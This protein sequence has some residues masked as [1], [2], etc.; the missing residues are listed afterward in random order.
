[1]RKN[2]RTNQVL[3]PGSPFDVHIRNMRLICRDFPWPI[4]IEDNT[5][6]PITWHNIRQAI[7]EAL[8]VEMT[9]AEWELAP[10]EKKQ[11]MRSYR[12]AARRETGV[13]RRIDWLGYNTSWVGLGPENIGPTRELMPGRS[14]I[15]ETRVIVLVDRRH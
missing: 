6:M 10:E 11:E 9:D 8:Q 13:P 7:Y 2:P 12:R 5:G 4:F 14:G 15:Y 1:M 3:L